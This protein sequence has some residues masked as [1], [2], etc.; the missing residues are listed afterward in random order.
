M[1][2]STISILLVVGIIILINFLSNELFFRI[3]TTADKTYTLSKATKNVLENLEEPITVTSYF[4][5]DLPPQYAKNQT[6]FKDLLKEYNRRSG[7]LLNFEF[8]DPNTDPQKEQEAAQN[9]IQPLLINVREK[10]EVTQKRAFMGA[11]LKAGEAQEIL[12]FIQPEGPMEYQLTTAV[13]KLAVVDKPSIGMIAGHGELKAQDLQE[14]YKELS[15]LYDVE[16]VDLNTTSEIPLRMKTVL[17]VKP[18][19]SIPDQHFAILDNY[20]AGG[21]N[22]CLAVNNVEGDFQTQQG[23]ASNNQVDKWLATK[24]IILNKDF[25]LDA[26]CSTI[27]VTQKQGFFSFQSQVQFPYFPAVSAFPDHPITQG[28]DQIAFPFASSINNSGTNTMTPIVTSS[29]N[30]VSQSPPLRFDIQKKWRQS[31]F[32]DGAKTLAAIFEGDLAGTGASGKL[33][34]F[35]DADFPVSQGRNSRSNSDNFSLLVNSV[36]F[37]SDDTGL[38]DLRTKGVSSRP[39][40]EIEESKVAL[41]KWGNFLIPILLVLALGLFKSQQNRNKRIKRMTTKYV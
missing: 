37:L 13:K 19:D 2:Q 28:I 14:V 10:D 22:I 7:G 5:A 18:V 29:P 21:G 16:T 11:I 30:S 1:K 31:D 41:L 32:P 38:I 39:I 27:G 23:T 26:K 34:L 20:L 15:I 36:D 9:G 40:K 33:I 8:L 3:D 17:M 35:G 24:G 25:V 12:P 4:T 6:D